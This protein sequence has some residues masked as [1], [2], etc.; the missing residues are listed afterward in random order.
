MP[1]YRAL[2]VLFTMSKNRLG[3]DFSPS[4]AAGELSKNPSEQG[5]GGLLPWGKAAL[6]G[7]R[8]GTPCRGREREGPQ[9]STHTP[10]GSTHTLTPAMGEHQPLSPPLSTQPLR[11]LLLQG[12][13]HPEENPCLPHQGLPEDT[14]PLLPQGCTVSTPSP[15]PAFLPGTP[16][17]TLAHPRSLPVVLPLGIP[18]NEPSPQGAMGGG[19]LP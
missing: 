2:L 1:K 7:R 14:F 16:L 9:G 10:R 6:P 12:D 17:L 19:V 3:G 4:T 13:V 8:E 15:H 18:Q 11:H 5:N